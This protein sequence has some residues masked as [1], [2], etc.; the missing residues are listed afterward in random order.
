MKSM[1]MFVVCYLFS[2][3]MAQELPGL[4]IE[5]TKLEPIT[6]DKFLSEARERNSWV[7]NKKLSIESATAF[8]DQVSVVNLS[9]SFSYSRGSFYQKAPMESFRSPQS[10]TYTLSGTIEGTGKRQARTGSAAAEIAR[11]SAN[12]NTL[13]DG[14]DV[15]GASLFLDAIRVKLILA[16]NQN[17]LNHLSNLTAAEAVQEFTDQ[18]KVRIDLINDFRYFSLGMASYMG[19]KYIDVLPEPQSTFLIDLKDFDLK[20]LIAEAGK[21]RTDLLEME[22]ALKLADANLILAKKN[23]NL[24]ISVS[25]YNT[26]SPAYEASGYS[27]GRGSSIGMSLSIPIPVSQ[28]YDSDLVQASNYKMQLEISL[29]EARNR[30]QFEVNQAFLQYNS[31]KSKLGNALQERK[32]TA[33]KLDQKSAKVIMAAYTGETDLI[34]AQ[35]NYAKAF[36]FLSK[37]A[38]LKKALPL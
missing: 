23:R 33:L 31:A 2:S 38:G 11:Q 5:G 7:L 16:A 25:V 1:L 36:I 24:D 30:V 29:E 15:D 19:R 22:A 21:S 35:I 28:L 8:K 10:N 13:L 4:A 26:Q 9:P 6:F 18:K 37:V 3:V 17:T 20:Q 14:V 34:D 32:K 12:L 27:Y